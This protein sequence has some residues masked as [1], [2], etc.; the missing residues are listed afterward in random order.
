[1][2]IKN[3]ISKENGKV[4]V[5]YKNGASWIAYEQSAY[6]LWL[7]GEYIP[8]IRHMKYLKKHIISIQF[9]NTQLSAITNN[10]SPF[11]SIE[12]DK[13]CVQIILRKNERAQLYQL[14]GKCLL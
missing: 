3:I 14:E 9:G 12:I 4:I 6:C 13:E 1:M 10:L 11:G 7:T 8:E 5:F 2:N